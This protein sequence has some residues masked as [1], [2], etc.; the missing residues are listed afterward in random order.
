MKT[1]S[2]HE[3]KDEFIG[4]AGTRERNNY[5]YELNMEMLSYLIKKVVF[6]LHSSFENPVKCNLSN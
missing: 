4:K 6:T 2:L 5:E 1:H 3:M